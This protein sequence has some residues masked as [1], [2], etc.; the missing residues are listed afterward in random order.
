MNRAREI[1][2]ELVKIDA[3]L[4]K[5]YQKQHEL[6]TE[7]RRIQEEKLKQEVSRWELKP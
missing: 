4:S 7:L 5:L 3:E 2:Q 6:H 1:D